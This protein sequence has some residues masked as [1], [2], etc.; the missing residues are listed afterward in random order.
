MEIPDN[1]LNRATVL[2]YKT[3]WEEELEARIK[4][5][6]L[7]NQLRGLTV[8]AQELEGFKFLVRRIHNYTL[9]V[10]AGIH[11][12]YGPDH[13]DV[14]HIIDLIRDSGLDYAPRSG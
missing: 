4:S 11:E 5:D 9:N 2:L 6:R 14:E 10:K 8:N 3:L 13:D 1:L 12:G 7:A